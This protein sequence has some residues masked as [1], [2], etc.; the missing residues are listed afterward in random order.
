MTFE[1]RTLV[2][3]LSMAGLEV[4]AVFAA[5]QMRTGVAVAVVLGMSELGT[6]L[7][8]MYELS[9]VMLGMAELGIVVDWTA[10]V[11]GPELGI[12]VDETA[13]FGRP[14]VHAAVWNV[15]VPAPN[16]FFPVT[17]GK[18]S[19][20]SVLC[21]TP[22][23]LMTLDPAGTHVSPPCVVPTPAGFPHEFALLN[24]AL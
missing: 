4:N 2:H 9:K 3:V 11:L 20:G 15:N 10:A 6:E 1:K 8:G 22:T 16:S 18:M 23:K 12:E 21:R 5:E 17:F 13:V 19:V 14:V 24:V 7:V